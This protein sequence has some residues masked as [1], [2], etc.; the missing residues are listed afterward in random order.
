MLRLNLHSRYVYDGI[1]WTQIAVINVYIHEHL[2][3]CAPN[4]YYVD[5]VRLM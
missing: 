4:Y 2:S 3:Q 5:L 1:Y